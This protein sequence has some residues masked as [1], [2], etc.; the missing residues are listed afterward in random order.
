MYVDK[1]D[2]I[3]IGWYLFAR[4]PQRLQRRIALQRKIKSYVLHLFR[5]LQPFQ[6]SYVD[7]SGPYGGDGGV[8]G[9]KSLDHPLFAYTHTQVLFAESRWWW[10]KLFALKTILI[11]PESLIENWGKQLE[12]ILLR[13]QFRQTPTSNIS[14]NLTDFL[15]SLHSYQLL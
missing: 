2:L 15:R 10:W 11:T 3:I 7:L 1:G 13:L 12:R 9:Q 8:T 5:P 4:G 14:I 6:S